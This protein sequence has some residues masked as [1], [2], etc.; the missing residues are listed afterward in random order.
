MIKL[1]KLSL[2]V[3]Y[4]LLVALSA[5]SRERLPDLQTI[6]SHSICNANI[7]SC[8]S[9]LKIEAAQLPIYVS[10]GEGKI[11]TI[12]ILVHGMDRQ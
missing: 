11:N 12:M 3:L 1:L 10:R 2:V 5:H 6:N 4:F 9:S 7:E 8:K